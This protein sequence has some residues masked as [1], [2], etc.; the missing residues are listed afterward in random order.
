MSTTP[1]LSNTEEQH[2]TSPVYKYSVTCMQIRYTHKEWT[3][4][5]YVSKEY[6][7][8]INLH[9]P[10]IPV[11]VLDSS[12]WERLDNEYTILQVKRSVLESAVEFLNQRDAVFNLL[13]DTLGK[14]Q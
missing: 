2:D 3:S 1:V 13:N 14:G 10:T 4:Y 8:E 11:K 7:I 9:D 6:N 12:Y 5:R